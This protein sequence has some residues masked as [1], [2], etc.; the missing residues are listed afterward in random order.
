MRLFPKIFLAL[1]LFTGFFMI[2]IPSGFTG[3]SA[4]PT[5]T[6]PKAIPKEKPN[7]V[8]DPVAMYKKVCGECH[9]S[10][11]PE[12]LPS[13]SWEKL[14]GS[15]EKHFETSVDIDHKTKAIIAPYLKMKGA[16]FSKAKIPQKIMQ[17][18]E[19]D[20]PLRITEVPY[21]VKKHRKIKPEDFQRKPIG[22]FANC[23]ACHLLADDWIFSRKIVI[24]E[25]EGAPKMPY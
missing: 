3:T 13:G 10:Y 24:P 21:I 25:Y 5:V 15:T 7:P 12:F 4:V 20:P 23:V 19:G 14:L 1:I 16:E 6:P 2:S 11:P 9:T 18:L 8:I 22:S 17:S